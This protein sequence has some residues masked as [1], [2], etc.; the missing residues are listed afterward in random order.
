VSG[1]DPRAVAVHAASWLNR[2]V[3]IVSPS[4]VKDMD[5]L[6]IS[7]TVSPLSKEGPREPGTGAYVFGHI[8]TRR[9]SLRR[10]RW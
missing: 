7:I 5:S 6:V 1:D 9:D 10:F 8:P 4:T 2:A 3:A